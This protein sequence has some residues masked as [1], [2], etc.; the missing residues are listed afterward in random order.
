M[1]LLIYD[2]YCQNHLC[3]HEWYCKCDLRYLQNHSCAHKWFWQ[4]NSEYSKWHKCQIEKWIIVK[5]YEPIIGESNFSLVLLY[6]PRPS[7]NR[8]ACGH[9]W[10]ATARN[11]TLSQA[12]YTSLWRI[13]PSLAFGRIQYFTP[14]VLH[15]AL[16]ALLGA[17]S[18]RENWPGPM[19]G[20]SMLG[21]NFRALLYRL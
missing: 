14:N 4:C 12:N 21:V 7:M 20:K 15:R 18:E 5:F 16:S 1:L 17:N 6:R 3:V 10:S 11:D 2:T 13:S 19:F 9:Q 8:I